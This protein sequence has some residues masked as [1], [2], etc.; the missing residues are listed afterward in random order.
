MRILGKIG[1]MEKIGEIKAT[2]FKPSGPP[3]VGKGPKVKLGTL[4]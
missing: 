3:M 2:E 1:L 4:R